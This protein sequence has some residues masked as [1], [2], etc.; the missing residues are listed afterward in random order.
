M[1][2]LFT[3]GTTIFC[4]L[5]LSACGEK[6]QTGRGVSSDVPAYKGTDNS[7]MASGWKAGDKASWEQGLKA[8]LQNT[9]NEYTKMNSAN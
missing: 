9:Q 8:R 5:A 7:F 6:P 3:L 4:A 2:L 1:R